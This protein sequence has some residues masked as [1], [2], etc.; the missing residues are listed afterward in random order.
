MQKNRLADRS[1]ICAL[2][3]KREFSAICGSLGF[4]NYRRLSVDFLRR[5][6]DQAASALLK[7]DRHEATYHKSPSRHRHRTSRA[8]LADARYLVLSRRH[9]KANRRS[10]Q[11]R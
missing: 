3:F 5:S 1:K 9:G 7:K 11:R 8:R 2:D 4:S 6:P 10:A